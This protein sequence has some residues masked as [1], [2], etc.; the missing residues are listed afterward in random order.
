MDNG[1]K[2]QKVGVQSQESKH[3]QLPKVG[4]WTLRRWRGAA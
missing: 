3:Q 2:N 1:G 4:N